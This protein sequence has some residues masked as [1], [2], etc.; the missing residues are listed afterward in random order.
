MTKQAGDAFHNQLYFANLVSLLEKYLQDLFLHEITS[1]RSALIKLGTQGKFRSEAL[2]IPYLLH[3]SVEDFLIRSMKGIVWHR[4]NDID[5][6]FQNV[7]GIKMNISTDLL[8]VLEKRHHIVH[9]NGHDQEGEKI[10]VSRFELMD[11][12]KLVLNFVKEIEQKYKRK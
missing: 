12:L 5:V 1:N 7:L 3:N 9:R 8:S 4:L 11:S 6:L 10:V 2:K